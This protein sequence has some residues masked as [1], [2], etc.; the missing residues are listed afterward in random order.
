MLSQT[1]AGSSIEH[2]LVQLLIIWTILLLL[3]TGVAQNWDNQ[4]IIFHLSTNDP[5]TIQLKRIL[6]KLYNS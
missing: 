5:P 6:Y 1:D 4:G 2:K 3:Q